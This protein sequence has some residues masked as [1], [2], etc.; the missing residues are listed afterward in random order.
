MKQITVFVLVLVALVM[1]SPAM[2]Q[3]DNTIILNDATPSITAS[4][5]LPPDSTGVVSF[6]LSMA[7]IV[8]TDSSG[9]IA[10]QTADSRVHNVELSLSPNSGPHTIKVE[11]LPGAMEAV[12]AINSLPD[13]TNTGQAQF[14]DSNTI[15]FNQE[16]LLQLTPSVPGTNVDL[17]V[18]MNTIGVITAAFPG[19]TIASQFIDSEG[20]IVANSSGGGVD[21]LNMVL[22]GGSYALT[23]LGNNL[24]ADLTAGVRVMSAPES[25]FPILQMPV[26]NQ[27]A[28]SANQTVAPACT[29]TITSASVNLRSGPGTGYSVLGYGYFNESMPVGG[30]NPEQNWIVVG[31]DDGSSGWLAKDL[32][33]LNGVCS[34]LTVFNIPLRD[35]PPAQIIVQAPPPVT[36]GGSNTSFSQHES[37]DEHGESE[38]HE[39]HDD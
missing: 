9:K 7:S 34:E 28:T 4:V 16:R 31:R 36:T 13:L 2:G 3:S 39:G 37:D 35:A 12:V 25:V 5:T 18:P 33:Q 17:S 32:T 8:V 26:S 24:T 19:G 15:T 6:S 10:F 38:E 14:I 30:T 23:L 21:G 22:D 20:R 29:A 1:I 27:I 11:R